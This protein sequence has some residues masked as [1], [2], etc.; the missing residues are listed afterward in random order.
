MSERKY[1]Y[2]EIFDSIQGEGMF[3][4]HW[5]LWLRFFLCNLQCNGFGQIDPTN[6]ETY[7]LPF[8]DFDPKTVNRVEDLPVWEKGCDSSYTWSKKYKHLMANKTAKEIVDVIAKRIGLVEK[9]GEFKKE[10]DLTTFQVDRWNEIFKSRLDWA[11]EKGVDK[12]FIEDLYKVIHLGS[13]NVQNK[14]INRKK[15]N[16]KI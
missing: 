15:A 13:I 3:T 6:P 2:S 12:D 10:T 11:I 16:F 9:I 14:I 7:D 8:L 1:Y 4:G 5:T